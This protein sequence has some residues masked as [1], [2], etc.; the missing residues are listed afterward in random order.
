MVESV[1]KG[2][3]E[4]SAESVPEAKG[5]AELL[6]EVHVA[7]S[8]WMDPEWNPVQDLFPPTHPY[9]RV[10][11]DVQELRQ[12]I[13]NR[14]KALASIRSEIEGLIADIPALQRRAQVALDEGG[15]KAELQR[16]EL[17]GRIAERKDLRVLLKRFE[18]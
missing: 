5:L 15:H 2:N 3:G 17:L 6:R 7:E 16:A 11:D 13:E 1:R 8:P 9:A 4:R 14:D 18:K 10:A 12:T